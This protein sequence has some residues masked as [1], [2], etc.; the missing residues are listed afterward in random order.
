MG[1]LNIGIY[2]EKPLSNDTDWRVMQVLDRACRRSGSHSVILPEHKLTD[3]GVDSMKMVEIT[4]ELE[5]A[6]AIELPE[7]GL[8]QMVTVGDLLSVVAS[9]A[10]AVP[11]L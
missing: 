8:A 5:K 6:F 9:G 10:V 4:F 2:K 7:S 1:T 3:L 11:A